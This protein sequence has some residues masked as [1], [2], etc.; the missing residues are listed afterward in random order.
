MHTHLQQDGAKKPQ[1]PSATSPRGT[2]M[3]G[4]PPVQPQCTATAS[5]QLSPSQ[6]HPKTGPPAPPGPAKAKSINGQLPGGGIQEVFGMDPNFEAFASN[7]AT[8]KGLKA[9]P[10]GQCLWDTR[11]NSLLQVERKVWRCWGTIP[12]EALQKHQE[13]PGRSLQRDTAWP[14]PPTPHCSPLPVQ[15]WIHNG[16]ELTELKQARIKLMARTG[17]NSRAPGVSLLQLRVS[18]TEGKPLAA[19]GLLQEQLQFHTQQSSISQYPSFPAGKQP[20]LLLA[21]LP[22]LWTHQHRR[23]SSRTHQPQA[24]APRDGMSCG[25][26]LWLLGHAQGR[27]EGWRAEDEDGEQPTHPHVRSFSA[28]EGIPGGS[29]AVSL[30][31]P[32]RAAASSWEARLARP[33]HSPWCPSVARCYLVSR[34]S[35]YSSAMS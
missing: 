32:S 18:P 16:A 27:E 1:V 28:S 11:R 22:P 30:P 13:G 4:P 23:A 25:I 6:H 35:R 31:T 33:L 9:D 34:D 17:K 3:W 20:Q 12:S 15:G 21:P 10:M 8:H 24:V 26:H 19:S 7:A 2:G 29:F 5:A 14:V